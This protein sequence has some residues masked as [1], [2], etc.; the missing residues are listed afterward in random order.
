MPSDTLLEQR[1]IAFL[2]MENWDVDTHLARQTDIIAFSVFSEFCGMMKQGQHIPPML[3]SW[4][5][6]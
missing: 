4:L 5:N 1:G 6:P 2:S 3:R